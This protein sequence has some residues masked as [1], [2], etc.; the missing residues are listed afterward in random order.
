[1]LAELKVKHGQ[2]MGQANDPATLAT[3][4]LA[5]ILDEIRKTE[6]EIEFREK[7]T[8]KEKELQEIQGLVD[9]SNAASEEA[10]AI[11]GKAAGFAAE[12]LKL[13]KDV[14][15]LYDKATDLAARMRAASNYKEDSVFLI[16]NLF[17]RVMRWKANDRE[18]ILKELADIENFFGHE[19][20]YW[21][22]TLLER[23]EAKRRELV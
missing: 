21:A 18:E 16:D 10:K 2:L 20:E 11:K 17:G 19:T 8:K 7:L 22:H 15:V 12:A 4:K 9:A 14:L 23:S 3:G 5:D 13:G 6:A 1:M